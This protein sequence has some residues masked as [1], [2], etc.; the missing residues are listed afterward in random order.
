MLPLLHSQIEIFKVSN[1]QS[2]NGTFLLF[3]RQFL[4]WRF[5][6][7]IGLAARDFQEVILR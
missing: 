6:E 4:L 1:I 5:T 7:G 2:I 3:S